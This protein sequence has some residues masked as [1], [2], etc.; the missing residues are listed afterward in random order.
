[1][2]IGLFAYLSSWY[3]EFDTSV[4]ARFTLDRIATQRIILG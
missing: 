1:M 2:L 3:M 4:R